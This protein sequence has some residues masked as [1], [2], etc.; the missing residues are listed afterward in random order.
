MDHPST[1]WRL[2]VPPLR[3]L[4][5]EG[6]CRGKTLSAVLGPAAGIAAACVPRCRSPELIL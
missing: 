3:L 5:L 2:A 6:G 1:S 4:L